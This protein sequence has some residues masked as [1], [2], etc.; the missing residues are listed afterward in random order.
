MTTPAQLVDKR[1]GWFPGR[2][3]EN[4][5]VQRLAVWGL[6]CLAWELFG[7]AVGPF[8]FATFTATI[9]ALGNFFLSSDAFV[10]LQSLEHMFIGYV[11]AAVVGVSVGVL[12]GYYRTVEYVVDPYVR[13]LFVTSLEALLPL[14]IIVFGVGL[15][16]RVVTVFLFAI[17]H[18]VMNVSA[19][20]KNVDRELLM[21]ARA[22]GASRYQTFRSVVIPATL[23]FV[24]AGLRL[25]L[26]HALKG[27]VVVEIWVFAATGA[28]LSNYGLYRQLDKFLALFAILLALGALFT[29]GLFWVQ[30]RLAPWFNERAGTE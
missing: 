18:I 10:L 15:K 30:R 26:G 28:L 6:I 24:L 19:G 25:G 2:A 13:A 21:T 11:L 29:D 23:P 7:R 12:I 22:F 1:T 3:W 9:K 17:L 16:L 27:M 20:V 5:W 8:Y 14:L 4:K